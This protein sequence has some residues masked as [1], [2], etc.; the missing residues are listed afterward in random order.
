MSRLDLTFS[1]AYQ[2]VSDFLGI[3]LSP[4]GDNLTK[5]KKIVDRAY[6]QFVYPSYTTDQGRR[7]YHTWSWL[8]K[9]Y[10]IQTTSTQYV[11]T[12]PIDFDRM[13]VQP[14]FPESSGYSPLSKVSCDWIDNIRSLGNVNSYPSYYAINPLQSGVEAEQQWEMWLWPI[15]NS[16]YDIKLVYQI[17]PNKPES[18]TDYFMGGPRAGEVILEMALGIAEQQED[19]LATSHHTELG[20]Q[21]L[22]DMIISDTIDVPDTVGK[23]MLSPVYAYERGYVKTKDAEIYRADR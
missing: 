17:H 11:Y 7:I 14:T 15:P 23:V 2:R 4:T 5:V 1:D 8:K 9:R 21:L 20:R 3:G 6:R 19:G 12:L 16:A 22:K 10:T 18:D 13:L